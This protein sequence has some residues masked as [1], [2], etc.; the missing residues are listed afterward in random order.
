MS[1]VEGSVDPMRDVEIINTELIFADMEQIERKLP[2]LQKKA[3]TKDADTLKEV[4]VLEKIQAAL[5]AGK[6]ARTVKN[7]LSEEEKLLVKPYNFL[8]MNPFVYAINVSQEDIANAS[9][10]QSQF[11]EKLQTPVAIVCAKLESEM[12]ELED[13]EKKEFIQEL[14]SV[15]HTAHIPTLDDLI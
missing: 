11:A 2:Q 8:T 1:H 6:L 10:I 12:M 9:A 7:D 3:K 4:S 13:T 14:L 5:N 15:E